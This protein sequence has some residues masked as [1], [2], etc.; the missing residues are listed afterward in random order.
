MRDS[1]GLHLW[2]HAYRAGGHPRNVSAGPD[3]CT[4][5]LIVLSA[6]QCGFAELVADQDARDSICRMVR[7][8][9]SHNVDGTRPW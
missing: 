1:S 5:S 2:L 6:G 3:T 9:S 4:F 8:S 7:V